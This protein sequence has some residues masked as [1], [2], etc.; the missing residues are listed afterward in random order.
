MRLSACVLR[1]VLPRLWSGIARAAG[2]ASCASCA[3]IVAAGVTA[4]DL[5]RG[6]GRSCR[7]SAGAPRRGLGLIL[8]PRLGGF[9]GC[10]AAPAVVLR[11]DLGGRSAGVVAAAAVVGWAG[12]AFGR[13]RGSA[14]VRRCS[15]RLGGFCRGRFFGCCRC[16]A[17]AAFLA[18]SAVAGGLTLPRVLPC[19]LARSG[20]S[21]AASAAVLLFGV[22]AAGVAV[23]VLRRSGCPVRGFRCCGC[24]CMPAA[25]RVA[26]GAFSR[27]WQGVRLLALRVGRRPEF[28]RACRGRGFGRLPLLAGAARRF[29][30]VLRA[31]LGGAVCLPCPRSWAG[32]SCVLVC[33]AGLL[34]SS[35]VRLS[36]LRRQGLRVAV[37]AGSARAVV[38]V[39]AGAVLVWSSSRPRAGGL[40]VIAARVG[41]LGLL[42]SLY[43][44]TASRGFPYKGNMRRRACCNICASG[45]MSFLLLSSFPRYI[46][47]F[48]LRGC[49][50]Y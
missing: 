38:R 8:P 5:G 45:G 36:P 48:R 46:L 32:F 6:F 13:G 21:G 39:S 49:T 15:D 31:A 41:R 44:R 16:A 47:R 19:L 18:A 27:F 22:V 1:R 11:S 40:G 28:G 7:L 50:V 3:E 42:T 34:R 29:K 35:A 43:T 25:L 33:P 12:S 30:C 23:L 14:G 2:A 4:P 17:L 10:C 20:A 37:V 24:P 26:S 9:W